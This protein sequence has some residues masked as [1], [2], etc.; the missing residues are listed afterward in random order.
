MACGARW[1]CNRASAAADTAMPTLRL[2][3][4]L[5][6]EYQRLFDT[7]EVRPER[8]AAVESAMGAVLAQQSRYQMVE[9]TTGVP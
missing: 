7:C 9:A 8:A 6:A 5:R 1:A 2:S 4:E 3:S